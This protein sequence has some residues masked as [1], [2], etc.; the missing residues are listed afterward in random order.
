SRSW[1]RSGPAISRASPSTSTGGPRR[2]CSSCG[3]EKGR[4][5]LPPPA[6]ASAEGA[7]LNGRPFPAT[8]STEGAQFNVPPSLRE[9]VLSQGE[10]PRVFKKAPHPSP[11]PE[12]EGTKPETQDKKPT[13]PLI[14]FAAAVLPK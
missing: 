14:P 10:G 9:R 12:G 11:L 6:T 2:S 3:P 1:P 8:A 7:Q 13:P 4:S 5:V